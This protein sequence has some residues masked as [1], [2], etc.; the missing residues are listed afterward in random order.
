VFNNVFRRRGRFYQHIGQ[1]ERE[2]LLKDYI[3]ARDNYWQAVAKH[4]E[5]A[6]TSSGWVFL[7]TEDRNN[8]R[9]NR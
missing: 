6:K 7:A 4:E 3:R 2:R 8:D 5:I 1:R 9:R